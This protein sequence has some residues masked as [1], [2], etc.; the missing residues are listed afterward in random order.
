MCQVTV[1][2][3]SSGDSQAGQIAEQL[4]RKIE[5]G[6]KLSYVKIFTGNPVEVCYVMLCEAIVATNTSAC[7]CPYTR[8]LVPLEYV[9]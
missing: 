9:S 5:A 3:W 8:Q 6:Q 7:L 4:A 1:A 2:R